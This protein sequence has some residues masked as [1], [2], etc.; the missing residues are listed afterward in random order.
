MNAMPTSAGEAR[1]LGEL[2]HGLAD[3]AATDDRLAAGLALDSRKVSPGDLFLAVA[4]SN[5][6]GRRF[7]ADAVAK[8]AIAVARE[9]GGEDDE[10]RDDAGV[11]EYA[12]SD[13]AARLVTCV[14]A[15]IGFRL[16]SAAPT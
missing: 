1:R 16:S 15:Q 8:G 11:P 12:V 5:S 9:H 7:I 4:G 13:L 14:P 6:D 10:L 2:L 3:V